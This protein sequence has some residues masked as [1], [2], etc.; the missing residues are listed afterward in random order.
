MA[1]MAVTQQR[2]AIGMALDTLRSN[3]LRSGLTILGIVI[4]VMTVIVISSVIN[5]LNN[6]VSNLVESFGTNI[7]WVTRLPIIAVRPTAEMLSR[8][9][10]SYDDAV[11]ISHL[12]HV[13]AAGASLRYQSTQF[14]TG[15][16]TAKHGTHKA[17]NQI[18][19]GDSAENADVYDQKV[20]KG[21]FLT[22]AD[23]D[24]A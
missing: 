13:A 8:K 16:A 2:E 18:L 9:Y 23:Q 15:M 3:K 7:L 4:G 11:A 14:N 21:R 10:L 1:S 20:A 12:P 17:E 24:R 19:S 6:N 5:G 22:T